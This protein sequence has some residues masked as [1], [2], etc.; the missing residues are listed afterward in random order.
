MATCPN[1]GRSRGAISRT[2]C[3]FHPSANHHYRHSLFDLLRS[4]A[5]QHSSYLCS[6][7]NKPNWARTQHKTASIG[8][9]NTMHG[10]PPASSA[11]PKHR[12]S[13]VNKAPLAWN[14]ALEHEDRK[15][16]ARADAAVHGVPPFQVDRK[17]LKDIV[18][19]KMGV[20]VARIVFLGSGSYKARFCSSSLQK[21]TMCLSF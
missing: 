5:L 1:M 16:E 8:C 10:T 4:V 14:W 3:H 21:L 12:T 6:C 17:L 11:A 2:G 7:Q 15:K 18:H 20:D 9:A 19:E 13:H